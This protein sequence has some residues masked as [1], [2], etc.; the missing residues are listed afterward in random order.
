M[1]NRRIRLLDNANDFVREALAKALL[2]EQDPA[3]WKYAIIHLTQAIELFLKERLRKEHPILVF[4]NV[5]RP[6]HTVTLEGAIS[7]LAEISGVV[8]TREDR[9]AIRIAYDLRNNITHYEFV[10]SETEVKAAFATLLGFA[11]T[12]G[13]RELDNELDVVLPGQLWREALKITE[14]ADELYQRARK[15]LQEDGISTDD[16]WVCLA[17]GYDLLVVE[18]AGDAICPVCGHV[19]EIVQC[20]DCY[21]LLYWRDSHEYETGG[22]VA[23]PKS[24]KV[25]PVTERFCED[26]YFKRRSDDEEYWHYHET[27][28]RR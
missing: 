25:Y 11:Q 9:T 10:L 3:H 2:A 19:E 20:P 23:D 21:T 12:F 13:K 16:C 26:C 8:L 5:D 6:K 7:R 24:D 28:K 4:S 18:D 1:S 15:S 17:C 22:T 14:Y 27:Q